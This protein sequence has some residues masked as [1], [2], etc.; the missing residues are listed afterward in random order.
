MDCN[1]EEAIGVAVFVDFREQ[2]RLQHP[3]ILPIQHE[4][5]NTVLTS[6]NTTPGDD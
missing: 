4:K 3:L 2:S 1:G 5:T 6:T